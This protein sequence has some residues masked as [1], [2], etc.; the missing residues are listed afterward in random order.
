MVAHGSSVSISL[1]FIF[2]PN[3]ETP[4]ELNVDPLK[5]I[6]NFYNEVRFYLR[7]FRATLVTWVLTYRFSASPWF[8]ALLRIEYE[9]G[10]N[11]CIL[12]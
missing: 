10:C 7:T 6:R 4:K 5:M 3:Q 1:L 12:T 9:I 8:V 11:R 2:V